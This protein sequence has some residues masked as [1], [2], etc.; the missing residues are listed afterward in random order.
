MQCLQCEI[1]RPHNRRPYWGEGRGG[2]LTSALI[3]YAT[4]VIRGRLGNECAGHPRGEV[5]TE[6][7]TANS[8]PDCPQVTVL[9][10]NHRKAKSK[11]ILK[12][13]SHETSLPI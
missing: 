2:V 7:L 9:E 12:Y 8:P 1:V 5:T 6:C 4:A 13:C 3:A 10:T 11:R